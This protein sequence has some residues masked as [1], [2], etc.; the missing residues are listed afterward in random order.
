MIK[1]SNNSLA[2]IFTEKELAL[3]KTVINVVRDIFKESTNSDPQL[4]L[5]G[6]KALYYYY[7]TEPFTPAPM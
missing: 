7:G 4:F 5:I 1:S 2:N 6:M 3:L